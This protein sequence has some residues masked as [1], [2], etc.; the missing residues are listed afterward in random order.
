LVREAEEEEKQREIEED[1][2]L[3]KL[4]IPWFLAPDRIYNH[5]LI[6]S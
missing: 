1:G 4:R 3:N 5:L 2:D 6:Y